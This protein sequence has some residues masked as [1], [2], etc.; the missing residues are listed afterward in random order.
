MEGY[1]GMAGVFKD[2]KGVMSMGVGY[3]LLVVGNIYDNHLIRFVSNL[4]EENPLVDIDFFATING[5]EV[6][7]RVKKAVKDIYK[8]KGVDSNNK[9]I[10][11]FQRILRTRMALRS[12]ERRKHYNVVNIH[13]PLEEFGF[14]VGPFKKLGDSILV[15]PWGSDVY[16]SGKRSRFLLKRL[17]K[18]A[19]RI[20]GTG[21]RFSKDVQKIFNVPESKFV[22]LDIGS[23]TIDYISEKRNDI[24]AED[25]R[26]KLG[27]SGEYFI[28]CGY[29]AHTEQHHLIILDAI[30]Q[31]KDMLPKETVLLLPL[32]Y[33]KNES[34]I[35]EIKERVKK[36]E[37][38]AVYYENYLQIEDLFL[39]RQST[40]MFI[41]VQ[42]TDA[43][44]QSVQEYILLSKNVLNGS[45]LRYCELEM[46]GIP[47]H[48]TD[49]LKSLPQAIR[50][51]FEQG[52][53]KVSES[54]IDYIASYG[55][56]P[57]IKKWNDYFISTLK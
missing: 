36:Y 29:N 35:K 57:W 52:P 10:R 19:D 7:D 28:T 49:T 27:L 11:K 20:C 17:Y 12:I 15:T 32:T 13:F 1:G 16:R 53:V 40:D 31:I 30:Y 41:H 38:R 21:N 22:K 56:K 2:D 39:V 51:S 48:L 8:V 3:K 37:M 45:W 14:A 25:A 50:K 42:S 44:A 46:D 24:G 6:S 34:Y 43:N 55:W 26:R 18:G 4:Y 5:G 9:F 54:T 23:E 47:Y 33:P